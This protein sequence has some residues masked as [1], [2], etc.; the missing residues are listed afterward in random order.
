LTAFIP[1][2]KYITCSYILLLLD[3]VYRVTYINTKTLRF[4]SR[5]FFRLQARS[6]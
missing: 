4:G 1:Y 3:L 6:T 5:L 2:S